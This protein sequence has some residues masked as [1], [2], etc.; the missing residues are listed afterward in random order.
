MRIAKEMA[1]IELDV[2]DIILDMEEARR[3]PLRPPARARPAARPRVPHPRAAPALG[4]GGLRGPGT[5]SIGAAPPRIE[6]NY[7]LV[8]TEADARRRWS[9]AC[10]RPGAS[11]TTSKLVGS[12]PYHSH[13]RRRR[14]RRRAVGEAY[15]MP[16]ATSRRSAGRRSSTRDLVLEKLAPLFADPD[17][18]KVAHNGKFDIAHLARPRHQRPRL[19][20]RHAARRLHPR[21]WRPRRQRDARA[22][23]RCQPEVAG[24]APPRLRDARDHRPHRQ[25]RRQAALDGP[26]AD[27]RRAALRLRERRLHPAPARAPREGAARSSTCGSSSPTWRCRS[28]RCWR[29]WRRPASPSTSASCARCRW[30]S[31]SRSP[32]SSRRPTRTS[33]TS[34]TSARRRSSRPCCSRS[35]R[36]RR[37]ARRSRATRPTRSRSKACAACT[38]SSTSSCAGAS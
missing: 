2:P 13:A 29:A 19:R 36:C 1:T 14:G 35:W 6:T 23:A 21:R 17:I 15:Y 34:S 28:C 27:R 22:P 16:S 3:R 38:R 37:R 26:D 12:S 5:A 24:V 8:N 33:A 11:P 32:T 31:T 10:A 9:S 25:E 18:E 4:R 7:T 20:L 30:A